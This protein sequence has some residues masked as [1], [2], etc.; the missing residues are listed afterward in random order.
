MTTLAKQLRGARL[1]QRLSQR[2]LADKSG[3]SL[4]TI[5][6]IEKEEI[7]P[8]IDTVVKLES[9]L[10]FKFQLKDEEVGKFGKVAPEPTKYKT[11]RDKIVELGVGEV[12]EF[13]GSTWL[14]QNIR[15]AFRK[16]RE[17]NQDLPLV[18]VK[19]KDNRI[20]I[21]HREATMPWEGP[22]ARVDIILK[23]ELKNLFPTHGKYKELKANIN[24]LG[25]D[26]VLKISFDTI[27]ELRI[28]QSSIGSFKLKGLLPRNIKTKSIK[29]TLF[30]FRDEDEA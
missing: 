10:D 25:P 1:E 15:M 5:H 19:C 14:A 12:L 29:L 11:L 28:A 21:F 3:V 24:K 26:D 20:R 22:D 30:V 27:H 9:T 23:T 4:M 17:T 8:H 6:R 18:A 7:R 16:D 2:A 13:P